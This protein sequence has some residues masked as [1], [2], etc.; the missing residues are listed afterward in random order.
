MLNYL[1]VN[2]GFDMM[3]QANIDIWYSESIEMLCLSLLFVPN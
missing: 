3:K 2:G 1:K